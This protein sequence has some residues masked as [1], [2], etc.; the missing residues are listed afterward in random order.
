MDGFM[1]SG[2]VGVGILLGVGIFLY[3]V[4]VSVG[5][6]WWNVDVDLVAK[7]FRV[8]KGDL[9]SKKEVFILVVCDGDKDGDGIL[10]VNDVCLEKFE[11]KDGFVDKDGCL[12]FDND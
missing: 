1:V 12:D 6:G 11:D 3:W 4:F 9:E 10:D 2:G 8:V 5:F 7:D